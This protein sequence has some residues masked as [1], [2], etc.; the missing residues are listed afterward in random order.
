MKTKGGHNAMFEQAFAWDR[1]SRSSIAVLLATAVT[2]FGSGGCVTFSLDETKADKASPPRDANLH[3]AIY[4]NRS[5]AKKE[6]AFAGTLRSKLTRLDPMP[7]ET[8]FESSDAFWTVAGLPP[9]KYRIEVS[10]H[11]GPEPGAPEIRHGNGTFKAKPGEDITA[12]VILR[13][14]RGFLI[15][16]VSTAAGVGIAIAVVA[17]IVSIFTIHFSLGRSARPTAAEARAQRAPF[18]PIPDGQKR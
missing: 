10:Q 1:F 8:V 17:A 4:E 15:A 2:L 18:T 16:G 14:S 11:A 12:R 7:A 3:V 13:D 6:T 5:A 9:G